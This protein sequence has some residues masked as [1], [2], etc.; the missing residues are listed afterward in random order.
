[1]EDKLKEAVR[2]YNKIASIYSKYNY[3][4]LMQFQ[5]TKFESLLRGKRVLDAG[6]GVGRDVEYFMDDEL[7]VIGIDISKN[8]IAEAKKIVKKG[9]FEVMDFRKMK[10]KAKS[11]D[12]IWCMASLYH[13]APKEV[14]KVLKEFF[15]VLDK[16]GVL[17]I[18]VYEGED[19]I[20]VKKLE[21]GE[22]SRTVYLYKEED[23]REFLE[24]AGFSIIKA[25]VNTTDNNR[26]LEVYARKK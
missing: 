24:D 25:E 17:Y 4:K 26:W 19:K 20:E 11:F 22:D 1:M 9:K 7:E 12:G 14:P 10:F 3:E 5:L 13:I 8:M 16:E 6:C 23:M 18:A 15:R 2:V 21:Y